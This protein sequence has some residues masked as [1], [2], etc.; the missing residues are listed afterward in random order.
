MANKN[1]IIWTAEPH[2]VAKIEILKNYLNAWFPIVGSKFDELLY[3]DGFAGPGVYIN[4]HE[5]S[6]LAALK[7]FSSW[8]AKDP[9]RLSISRISA[10][11]I[12]SHTERFEIL[13]NNVSSIRLPARVTSFSLKGE[14]ATVMEDLLKDPRFNNCF[15]GQQ[16]LLIFADPFGGTGIPFQLF[17]RCLKSS[18]SELILNFDADGIARIY[19]GRNPGWEKQL[20][21]LFGSGDWRTALACENDT[22]AVRS[23]KALELYKKQLL[24]IP[25]VEFVWSFEMRGKKDRINYYLIFATRNRLG[26]EKMKE[27]MRAIDKTGQYCF[28]DAFFN[29]HVLFRA[30][31]AAFFAK[32]LHALYLG[33]TASYSEIDRYALNETPLLNPKGMLEYLSR[34]EMIRVQPVPG[35]VLR[36]HT[37][38]EARIAAIEFVTQPTKEKQATLF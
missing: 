29:Q 21:E 30:D 9:E 23:Q 1:S 31:D 34:G 33:T 24:L 10:F 38:P 7:V 15:A 4:H 14:F 20:D 36:A 25:G 5:G 12:E 19:S 32:E 26:M 27:A 18:G 13:H 35:A 37:F 28:S 16:P 6:P 17:E 8:I 11:F 2:T 22:L 3:I